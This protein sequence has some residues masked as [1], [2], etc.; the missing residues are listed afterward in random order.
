MFSR[1]CLQAGANDCGGTLIEESISSAS[2]EVAGTS[3][4]PEELQSFILSEARTPVERNTT[5]RVLR[6]FAAV[7]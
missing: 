4:S 1:F 5:Y 3:V 2:G 6:R 7:A